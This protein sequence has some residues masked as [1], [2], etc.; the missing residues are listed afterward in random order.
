MPMKLEKSDR[1]LLMWAALILLP[2]FVAVALSQPEEEESSI[3]SSYSTQRRGAKAAYL[4]LKEGGYNVERWEKAPGRLP[5]EAAHTA[6]VLAGPFSPAS[7]EDKAALQNYLNR[8]GR[9]VATSS[10]SEFYLPKADIEGEALPARL[11]NTYKPQLLSAITRGGDIKMSPTGYWARSSTS[12]LTHYADDGRPIV[13]T[14]KVGKGEVVWWAAS[15]PLSNGNIRESGN[16]ALLLNS[17]GDVQNTHIFWDEY[18]HG[19]RHTPGE[20]FSAAS[21]KF[22]ALQGALIML[23]LILTYSRRNGP[24]HPLVQTSRLSPLEFVE[25]LGSL[26]RR[27]NATRSA[28]EIPY[29]RFRFLATRQLGLKSDVS[30]PDLAQALGSRFGYKDSQL[31]PLLQEIEKALYDSELKEARALDLV[32]QL[33]YH[34]QRLK[35]LPS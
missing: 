17:L 14:Y 32:Q 19:F 21:V 7:P 34:E 13:V 22:A 6:L 29:Q 20:Y 10:S 11:P 2:I 4:L 35:L 23:A 3:P 24:I 27:A 8:G 16:L 12:F 15:T 33:S 25:T 1:R 30:A 18:F 31:G 9:I 5:I 26:Y 28:L